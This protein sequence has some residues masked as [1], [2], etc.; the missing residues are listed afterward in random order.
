MLEYLLVFGINNPKF[1][2]QPLTERPSLASRKKKLSKCGILS[3]HQLLSQGVPGGGLAQAQVE[4][5]PRDGHRDP[6]VGPWVG[7][8][9]RHQG[10]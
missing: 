8:G 10:G 7:R 4:L 2:S 5:Q 9:Q 6:G 1:H 3:R